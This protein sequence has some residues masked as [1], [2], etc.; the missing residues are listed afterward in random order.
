[1]LRDD[2]ADI[3]LIVFEEDVVFRP[4]PFDQVVL[5]YEGILFRQGD[6]RVDRFHL[7]RKIGNHLPLVAGECEILL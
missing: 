2:Q 6:D 7:G 1:M 5:Q 4:V 3:S